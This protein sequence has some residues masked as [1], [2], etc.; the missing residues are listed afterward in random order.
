MRLSPFDQFNKC[1]LD[2]RLF[3][4]FPVAIIFQSCYSRVNDF[5]ADKRTDIDNHSVKTSAFS[6]L[7]EIALV[8]GVLSGL[9]D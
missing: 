2:S 6:D 4:H 9:G 7:P 1:A 5:Q 8:V 3:N